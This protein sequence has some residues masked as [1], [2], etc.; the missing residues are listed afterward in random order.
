MRPRSSR[1]FTNRGFSNHQP[2]L[3]RTASVKSFEEYERLYAEAAAD[4]EAFWAKQAE[5]LHWFK[6]WDTVLEWN[7]PFAKWFVGGKLNI[8]YNCLDRHL[9]TW[10]KNKAAIIWEGEP[11]DVRTLTYLQLHRQ[12]SK[13]AN[14]L[15]KLGVVKGDRVALYMPLIPELAIAM[16]A[17]ARIGATHTVIFGGFSADAIRDR[18]NDGQ[19]KLIVTADGGY[20]RGYG[21]AFERDRRRC[22]GAVPDD[23]ERC[24]LPS[25]WFEDRLEVRT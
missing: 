22:G 5:D 17:C 19:C 1:F 2:S 23:R 12:V 25:N 21:S 16:L 14:V 4:P 18:V 8:S 10:R 15:K 9:D 3:P 7:E 11:G 6:K 24:R 20:R 13:F